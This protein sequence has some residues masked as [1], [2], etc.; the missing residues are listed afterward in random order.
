MYLKSILNPFKLS[1]LKT[2]DTALETGKLHLYT[3]IRD[4]MVGLWEWG[5]GGIP[6]LLP[7]SL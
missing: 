1:F 6:K 5:L 3:V 4:E 2:W 7:S